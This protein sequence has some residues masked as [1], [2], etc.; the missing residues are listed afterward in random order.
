MSQASISRVKSASPIRQT[1]KSPSPGY[2]DRDYERKLIEDGRKFLTLDLPIET[3]GKIDSLRGKKRRGIIVEEL[4]SMAL[5]NYAEPE[6]K[7]L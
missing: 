7:M 2:S 6:P 5:D 3:L 1:R 4:L